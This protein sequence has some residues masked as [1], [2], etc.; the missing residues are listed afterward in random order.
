MP[1]AINEPKTAMTATEM[2]AEQTE[3]NSPA[4]MDVDAG[5][6]SK[7]FFMLRSVTQS[8]QLPDRFV[9]NITISE[10]GVFD[11]LKLI[12]KDAQLSLS[13]DGGVNGSERYGAVSA[14][15]VQG[16]LNDVMEQLSESM[17]FFYT[18]KRKTLFIQ[19]EQQFVVELPPS[20]GDDNA[21][22]LTNTLQ[23]LGAKDTYIDRTSRSLVFKTN[24]KS[25]D[26]IEEYL[27]RIRQTRSLIV[28]DV[29]IFQV[30]LADNSD[31]GIQWNTFN[32]QRSGLS[33][34]PTPGQTGTGSGG[35]NS[36]SNGGTGSSNSA[37]PISP[38]ITATK[39]LL[40]MGLVL[41]GSHFQID[42]LIK[43]LK[44]QGSVKAVSRPRI[45]LISGSK[46]SLRVGNVITF[47][48]K[49]GTN[50]SNTLNQVTTETKDLKTGLEI[51]LVGDVSDNTV[52][53]RVGLSIS[54]IVKFDQVEALGTSFKLPQTADR[55]LSTVIRARPGDMILIGGI[56][57]EKHTLNANNGI[58]GYG[59]SKE[60]TRS[61]I[62]LTLRARVVNFQSKEPQAATS[63]PAPAMIGVDSS[64]PVKPIASANRPPVMITSGKFSDLQK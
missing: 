14:I 55:E 36:G 59:T 10:S 6:A 16:S 61:E 53:S 21:A 43:F 38:G 3:D 19:Q 37:T 62:V 11:A 42:N 22:E 29:N 57:M 4:S 32:W 7:D 50:F 54:E 31:T 44:T 9:K 20:L 45:A 2:I 17:G 63:F 40:G 28:Y 46:G 13:V 8:E 5:F 39:S 58:S 64:N 26:K 49:V 35:S 56:N 25:L 47:V 52:T 1:R 23:Y 27:K 48:S 12:C 33:A 41:S 60:V 30:D 15:D 51:G 24:R 34:V 18:L